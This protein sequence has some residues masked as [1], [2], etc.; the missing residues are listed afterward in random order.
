MSREDFCLIMGFRFGKVNLDPHVEDHSE[1]RMRVFPNIE[2][3]KGEHLLELVNKDVKFTNL[4]DEGVDYNVA[5]SRRT[6]HLEK[7]ASNPKYEANYVL[8]G[9]VFPLKIWSL[10]TFSNSILWWR[11]DENVI[12]RG[13]ACSNR[14]SLDYFKKVTHSIPVLRSATQGSSKGKSFHTRVW[15][16][17]RH[18]VHV[19]T[20]VSRIHS[21]EDVHVPAVEKKDIQEIDELLK[22]LKG[23]K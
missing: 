21:K 16:K 20:E 3:L 18:E 7:L 9:F 11:K 19:R 5:V 10:E 1:F 12:P 15:T 13:V 22:T 23:Q 6:F 4:D 14:S 17:V 8:Y 2:N